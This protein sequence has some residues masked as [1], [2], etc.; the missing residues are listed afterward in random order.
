LFIGKTRMNDVPPAKRASP[1]YSR[2]M[3]CIRT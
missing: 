1:W 3:P 2:A